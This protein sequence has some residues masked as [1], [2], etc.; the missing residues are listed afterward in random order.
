MV[1]MS[2]DGKVAVSVNITEREAMFVSV[3]GSEAVPVSMETER[4]CL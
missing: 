4:Q 3:Y 1:S 2:I